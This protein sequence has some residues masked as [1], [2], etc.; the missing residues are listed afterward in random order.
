VL[1]VIGGI[2]MIYYHVTREKWDKHDLQNLYN[3]CDHN[4][5][6]AI[7]IFCSHW[8]DTDA[9]FASY[10]IMAIHLHDNIN[11]ADDYYDSF[12]NNGNILKIDI[13]DDIINV[14]RDNIEY[15]HPIVWHDDILKDYITI[16][17]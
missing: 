14:K 10:H 8:P 1:S 15:D 16:I 3:F 11:D 4:E 17:R 9:S 13:P 2:T 6:Q 7:E 5:C 12:C